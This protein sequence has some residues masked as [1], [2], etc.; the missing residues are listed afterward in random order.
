MSQSE[1]ERLREINAELLEAL[2]AARRMIKGR[3]VDSVVMKYIDTAIAKAEGT[4]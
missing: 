4:A 2:Q 1:I 3:R